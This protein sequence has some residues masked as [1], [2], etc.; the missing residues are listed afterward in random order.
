MLAELVDTTFVYTMG[1]EGGIRNKLPQ[2]FLRHCALSSTRRFSPTALEAIFKPILRQFLGEIPDNMASHA[3]VLVCATVDLYG[4]LQKLFPQTPERLHVL[5][6]VQDL[7]RVV[8]SLIEACSSTRSSNLQLSML[9][10]HECERIFAD[11]LSTSKAQEECKAAIGASFF[12]VAR[13]RL[14]PDP[15]AVYA[16]FQPESAGRWASHD[17]CS[18]SSVVYTRGDAS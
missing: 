13:H 5:F 7:S 14:Q 10:F 11:R 12:K 9:W 16:A 8:Q 1:I 17:R 2:R 18:E 4:A 15:E 3:N 6:S